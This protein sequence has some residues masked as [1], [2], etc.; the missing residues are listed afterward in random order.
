MDESSEQSVADS[1]EAKPEL[2]PHMPYLLQDLWALGSSVDQI[3]ELVSG[4]KLT[5]G[6]SG[7]LDLGCGKGAVGIRIAA[8]SGLKIT[9]VDLMEDFL[10]EAI[11]KAEFYGV[12]NLCTFIL[13]D[14][15]DYIKIPHQF[16]VVVLASLGHILGTIDETVLKLRSQIKPGGFMIIDDGFLKVKNRLNRYGYEHCRNHRESIRSLIKHGDRLLAEIDTTSVNME[17]NR[18]YLEKLTQRGRE[19]IR[20]NPELQTDIEEYLALQRE[21]CEILETEIQGALWLIRKKL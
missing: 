16:E 18:F 6:G 5:P 15:H 19:L 8:G 20:M 4:L 1:L 9:G 2:L 3:S 21:E 12:T 11:K 10:Q 7:I 13:K 17:I 14:I